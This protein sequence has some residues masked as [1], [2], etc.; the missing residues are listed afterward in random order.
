M[1]GKPLQYAG[2]YLHDRRHGAQVVQ[3]AANVAGGAPH[4][5]GRAWQG[6]ALQGMAAWHASALGGWDGHWVVKST[7]GPVHGP[8]G[9][10]AANQGGHSMACTQQAQRA[11][12]A[13]RTSSSLECGRPPRDET[14]TRES[15]T[16]KYTTSRE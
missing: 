3:D 9:R 14:A 8:A 16:A 6:L 13:G 5:W 4:L 2:I 7:P 12:Q 15:T 11:Q 1:A 10:L